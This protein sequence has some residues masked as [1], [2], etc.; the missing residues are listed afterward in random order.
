VNNNN[1]NKKPTQ[2]PVNNNNNNNKKPTQPPVNNNNRPTNNR[3]KPTKPPT[4][5]PTGLPTKDPTR[6]PTQYPTR[7]PTAEPTHTPTRA[8]TE[9]PTQSPTREP[10]PS[11]T[12]NPTKWKPPTSKPTYSN[13]I[14]EKNENERVKQECKVRINLK[15]GNGKRAS[16]VGTMGVHNDYLVVTKK[17]KQG[18]NYPSCCYKHMY[19]KWGCRHNG[20]DAMFENFE[21]DYYDYLES[22]EVVIENAKGGIYFL[23][24]KH[25]FNDFEGAYY[26]DGYEDFK[27]PGKMTVE[28]NGEFKGGFS[29]AKNFK[30]DTHIG[31]LPNREVNPEYNGYLKVWMKCDGECNCELKKLKKAVMPEDGMCDG[32]EEFIIPK[33]NV[34]NENVNNIEK[35]DNKNNNEK[36]TNN[37]KNNNN[38]NN[39]E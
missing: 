8:P 25:Y 32:F 17:G 27:V 31:T 23:E 39:K 28:V 13:V 6:E 12:A 16:S 19:Q 38:K 24:S 22:E 34:E 15:F 5:E 2:P 9:S 33:E 11:P 14:G 4:L 26:G 18:F 10:T 7:G 1:N 3:P 37:N 29:H 20:G 36:N 30:Q 21:D 35:N